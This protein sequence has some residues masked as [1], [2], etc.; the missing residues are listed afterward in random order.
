MNPNLRHSVPPMH[1]LSERLRLFVL[2]SHA[3]RTMLPVPILS[4]SFLDCLP[5][6]G[7][8]LPRRILMRSPA[9]S[10]L[11]WGK[12]GRRAVYLDEMAIVRVLIVSAERSSMAAACIRGL[13]K[14]LRSQGD[15]GQKSEPRRA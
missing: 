2:L 11:G 15:S 3:V 10:R 5:R 7:R 13:R 4:D 12:N 14:T 1:T 8:I 9:I 6:G